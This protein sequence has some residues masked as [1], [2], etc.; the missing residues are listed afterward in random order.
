MAGQWVTFWHYVADEGTATAASIAAALAALHAG[1]AKATDHSTFP[2]CWNRLKTAANLLDD[3]ELPGSLTA[4]D[5]A[6]LRRA[7]DDGIAALTSLSDPP[8][9][10]HG[11]PHRFNILAVEG[12]AVFIDLET[13]ELGPLEWDLA[14]LD[15][16]VVALYPADLD[17]DL[18]QRC[19]IADQC[20][21]F[22]VVLAR[23]R[24]RARH[25]KPR[26]Q[27]LEIVRQSS[28]NPGNCP[29]DPA[30]IRDTR[31]G[32]VAFPDNLNH[33]AGQ[34][35]QLSASASSAG[36][37]L[38]ASRPLPVARNQDPCDG[39]TRTNGSRNSAVM[40]GTTPS[41]YTWSNSSGHSPW[42]SSPKGR[43]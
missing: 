26:W 43:V 33:V 23:Y 38:P 31:S 15:E 17:R 1:L 24:S 39:W 19:R 3:P 13:V 16:E 10:L 34:A 9:V 30:A 6:L 7:L 42:I 18:L 25:A 2:P 12:E 14:H 35:Q 29:T 5:R 36:C 4:S 41:R 28:L 21:H 20:S 27:H 8:H 11:S 32:L 37:Q 40:S 22:D